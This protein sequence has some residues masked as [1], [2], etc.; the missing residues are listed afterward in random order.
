MAISTVRYILQQG[1]SPDDIVVLT[2]Y[3]GQLVE[4]RREL[5][6]LDL[7]VRS[8]TTQERHQHNALFA[9]CSI[10]VRLLLWLLHT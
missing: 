8:G 4:I 2:A 5:Q 9:C 3:L 7:D 10:A 6:K 1:Y